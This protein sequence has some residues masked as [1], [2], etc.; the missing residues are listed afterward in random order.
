MRSTGSRKTEGSRRSRL[1]VGAWVIV[2][3][4]TAVVQILGADLPVPLVALLD[5]AIDV[6]RFE[7]GEMATECR[8][9]RVGRHAE[10]VLGAARRAWA[11]PPIRSGPPPGGSATIPPPTPSRFKSAAVSLRASAA[12]TLRA[13]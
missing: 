1:R 11:P 10:V 2:S 13:M 7:R 4:A 12:S 5:Q 8:A 3:V 9:G 6:D